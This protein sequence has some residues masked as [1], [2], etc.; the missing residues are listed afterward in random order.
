MVCALKSP[1]LE[2]KQIGKN[3]HSQYNHLHIK[4]HQHNTNFF[5]IVYAHIYIKL[6]YNNTLFHF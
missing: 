6:L 2:I 1:K 5:F 4:I 3:P